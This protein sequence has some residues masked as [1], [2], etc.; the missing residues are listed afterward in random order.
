MFN[1][2]LD[3]FH[4]PPFSPRIFAYLAQN[5]SVWQN[6]QFLGLWN[7]STIPTIVFSAPLCVF[8]PLKLLWTSIGVFCMISY[9][10]GIVPFHHRSVNHIDIRRLRPTENDRYE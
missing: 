2:F 7:K 5:V 8:I 3:L 9:A 6:R 10:K 4:N 1:E